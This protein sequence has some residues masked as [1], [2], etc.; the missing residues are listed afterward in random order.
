MTSRESGYLLT[1]VVVADD[2]VVGG[3]LGRGA[4]GK[5][6]FIAAM[7]LGDGGLLQ[8]TFASPAAR[9]Q[10]EQV[11]C[12]VSQSAGPRHAYRYLAEAQYRLNRRLR[13]APTGGE[14]P[15]CGRPNPTQP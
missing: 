10:R 4:E 7:E 5:A 9:S 6:A 8:R 11:A 2:G 13:S 12:H 3:N 14:S 15:P 1:G